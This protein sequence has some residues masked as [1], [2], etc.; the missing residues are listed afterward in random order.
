MRNYD[1]TGDLLPDKKNRFSIS[2]FYNI[3]L[4]VLVL[5][6]VYVYLFAFVPITGESMENTFFDGQYC[7]VM[8]NG[9]SVNRGDI[10]TLNT[11]KEGEE[12]HIIIKRVIGTGGDKLVFMMSKDDNRKF[13]IYRC[14]ANSYYFEK[15][16][17]PY[18]KE[19]MNRYSSVN[20]NQRIMPYTD[21]LTSTDLST[22]VGAK[23]LS[24][25]SDFVIEVPKNN[26]YFLGDNRNISKDSRDYGFRP[27]SAVTTKVLFGL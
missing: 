10:V 11:A 3:L 2:L 26:I 6:L 12:S 15:L 17:E 14:T 7:F 9:F 22:D 25:I 18:I 4:A 19:D 13:D 21:R 24:A 8:R 16:N 5:Y 27:V 1:D 20:N 23:Y